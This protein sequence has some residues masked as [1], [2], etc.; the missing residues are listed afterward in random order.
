MKKLIGL[1]VFTMILGVGVATVSSAAGDMAA[2]GP[3]S[4]RGDLLKIEGDFYVVKDMSGKETRMHVDQTTTLD[5]G[6]KTGDKVEAQV[7][8]KGHAFSINHANVA[9]GG[10]AA[11]GTQSVKGDLLKIEGEFY[12]VHDAAGHEVKL[13]V[14]QTTKLEGGPFKTGDKV[15]AQVTDKSHALSMNHANPAK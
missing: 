13:H 15:E 4:I 2:P 3:Q 12:T 9:S 14:D 8:D 11:A 7:T 6:F 5:G 10:M 1:F